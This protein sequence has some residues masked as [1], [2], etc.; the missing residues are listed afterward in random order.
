[1]PARFLPRP[2]PCLVASLL[3]VALLLALP[4]CMG[5]WELGDVGG[6]PYPRAEAQP[7]SGCANGGP[8]PCGERPHDAGMLPPDGSR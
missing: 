6:L 1:M 5:R 3:A 8:V 7:R 4:G 2:V